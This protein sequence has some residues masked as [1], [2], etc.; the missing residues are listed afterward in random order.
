MYEGPEI[1]AFLDPQNMT[2]AGI[3]AIYWAMIHEEKEK[4]KLLES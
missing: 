1:R 4:L 2:S 3:F